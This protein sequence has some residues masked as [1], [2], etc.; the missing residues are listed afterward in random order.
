MSF[1][2][3]PGVFPAK[4]VVKVV[5]SRAGNKMETE[6]KQKRKCAE[7]GRQAAHLLGLQVLIWESE[8]KEV[9]QTETSQKALVVRETLRHRET[10]S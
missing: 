10:M 2:S 7:E 1:A 9:E 5:L 6:Q 3:V 8:K 4:M